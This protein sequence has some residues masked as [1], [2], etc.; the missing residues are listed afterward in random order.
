[1]KQKAE[2]EEE[3]TKAKGRC[4]GFFALFV[5]FDHSQFFLSPLF[6]CLL[7]ISLG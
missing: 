4:L 6:L 7:K 1:V 3:K 5:V 2:G